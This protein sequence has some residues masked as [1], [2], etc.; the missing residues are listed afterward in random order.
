MLEEKKSDKGQNRAQR[1]GAELQSV[2]SNGSSQKGLNMPSAFE[3][4]TNFTAISTDRKVKQR[5]L[6]ASYI[7]HN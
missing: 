2:K 5:G 7:I 6:G 4:Y 3:L 1:G